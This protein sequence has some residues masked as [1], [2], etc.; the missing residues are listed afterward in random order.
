M[1][2]KIESSKHVWTVSTSFWKCE[3]WWEPEEDEAGR[4]FMKHAKSHTY[5]KHRLG[6]AIAGKGEWGW[7][8]R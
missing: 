4:L 1:P 5:H 8:G 6:Y 2:F 3:L 7:G